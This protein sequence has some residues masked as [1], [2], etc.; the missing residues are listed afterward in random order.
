[1]NLLLASLLG[2]LLGSIPFG[3]ILTRMAGHGDIRSIGSGNIGATNVLRTGKKSLAL[4]TLFLDAGKGAAA[5]GLAHLIGQPELAP[6]AGGFA[7]L[8]HIFPVWLGFSGGKGVATALGTMLAIAW[9]AGMASCL[10]WLAIALTFRYSSLS[11][12]VAIVFAPTYLFIWA[13]PAIAA[14]AIP[15]V[16]IILWR[17]KTNIARLIRHEEPKIGQKKS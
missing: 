14:G 7:L 1:M 12:I 4:A 10:T 17:H 3:L 2:Y 5:I 13:S 15:L 11:A 16:L 8:G 6:M 9:P